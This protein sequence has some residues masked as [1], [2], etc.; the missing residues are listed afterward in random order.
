M[1]KLK[2][3]MKRL[4]LIKNNGMCQKLDIKNFSVFRYRLKLEELARVK[5]VRGGFFQIDL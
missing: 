5:S 2:Q 1:L 3:K 4:E